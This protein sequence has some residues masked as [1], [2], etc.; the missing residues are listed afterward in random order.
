MN[1]QFH[2]MER[3]PSELKKREKHLPEVMM[4]KGVVWGRDMQ[5][6]KKRKV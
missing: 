2:S 6:E 1:H 3:N 5:M 4:L